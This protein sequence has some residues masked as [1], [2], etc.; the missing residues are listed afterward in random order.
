M[1]YS[2]TLR[3]ERELWELKQEV[4]LSHAHSGLVP[5]EW[6]GVQDFLNYLNSYFS[7]HS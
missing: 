6:L 2:A 7:V 3:T 5:T 4:S 1:Q